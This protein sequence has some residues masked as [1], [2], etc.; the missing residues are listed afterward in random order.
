MS[1][2]GFAAVL[3]RMKIV[4]ASSTDSGLSSALGVSPQTLSSWKVRDSVPYSICIELALRHGISLDWLLLG[5]GPQLRGQPAQACASEV[6][7]LEQLR[8]LH[9]LD[10][11]AI[12]LAVQEKHRLRELEQQVQA[13]NQQLHAKA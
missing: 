2:S 11:Q 1:A 3:T 5:E 10:L 13:L 6:Q 8:T 7:L 4:T 9:P 12:T